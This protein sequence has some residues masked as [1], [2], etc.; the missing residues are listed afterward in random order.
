[1]RN[2]IK[3]SLFKKLRIR[4]AGRDRQ[5]DLCTFH[6]SE[7]DAHN[8]RREWSAAIDHYK[9][10]LAIN[11]ALTAIWIQLGHGQRETGL[12][13]DAER[14]YQRASE[15][16]PDNQDAKFFLGVTREELARR[17][18]VRE[19]PAAL[20]VPGEPPC[21]APEP[22]EFRFCPANVPADWKRPLD[23][24]REKGSGM[25][26]ESGLALGV[27]P[28]SGAV[29]DIAPTL[30]AF[31]IISFPWNSAAAAERSDVPG[32]VSAF[33][34]G[35]MAGFRLADIWFVNRRMLRLRLEP[36][37]T[38][39]GEFR[40]VRCFQRDPGDLQRLLL[41]AEQ[42]VATDLATFIDVVTAN[43]YFPLLMSV[44]TG[45][46]EILAVTLLP[47]PSLCRGGLHFGELLAASG[48]PYLQSLEEAGGRL[49]ETLLQHGGRCGIG[50][51]EI[52]L[53][54]AAGTERIFDPA[55]RKWLTSVACITVGVGHVPADMHEGVR[56]YLTGAITSESDTTVSR[57]EGLLLRMPADAVPS[58]QSIVGSNDQRIG[59]GRQPAAFVLAS[60]V[61]GLPKWLLSPP[62]SGFDPADAFGNNPV[63][64]TLEVPRSG[65]SRRSVFGAD[66]GVAQPVAAIRFRRLLHPEEAQLLAPSALETDGRNAAGMVPSVSVVHNFSG[67]K[68]VL[69][70]VLQSL[71]LQSVGG[72]L[73]V[74]VAG[75][76]ADESSVTPLLDHLFSARGRFI[77]CPAEEAEGA[78]LARAAAAVERELILFL[79]DAILLH[80][81]RTVARLAS[82]VG[83]ANVASASCML[84][85]PRNANK[86]T[87]LGPVP[88]ARFPSVGQPDPSTAVGYEKCDVLLTLPPGEWPA[89]LNSSRL[90]LVRRSEWERIGGFA[91]SS[92]AG[93]ELATLFWSASVSQGQCHLFTTAISACLLPTAGETVQALQPAAES[94]PLFHDAVK[95]SLNLRRLVA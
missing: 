94:L 95:V 16:D 8:A 81:R 33:S 2:D 56:A 24:D 86:T 22:P 78:R 92:G 44:C 69:A 57:E 29:D 25:V 35:S 46:G 31:Q 53:D 18:E 75:T 79:G 36:D 45:R 27:I 58:L 39:E 68:D 6:V 73:E 87:K 20:N 71:A 17:G 77:R 40:I 28:V 65:N 55:L 49:L 13:E 80:D 41:L 76:D 23:W 89:A 34:F 38:A 4:L 7:G 21:E 48:R 42:P 32:P 91:A 90:F 30:R 84:V 54:S 15:T 61:D 85:G 83:P 59:K 52:D 72:D 10:A 26:Y 19:E 93:E 1:M 70:A 43:P 82:L 5:G 47:F 3:P 14:S 62:P 64:P 66:E 74:L 63:F 88:T 51:V 11:P 9:Q 12:L 37:R 67:D 60:S 50:R